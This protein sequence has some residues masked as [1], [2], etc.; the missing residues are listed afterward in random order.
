MFPRSG[1]PSEVL[2]VNTWFQNSER[3]WDQ[4]HHHLQQ[5]VNRHQRFADTY[6]R[7]NPTYQPGQLVWLATQ[8]IRLRQPCR[9]LSPKYIGPFPV[10]RQINPVTYRLHL[11]AQYRI[12]P[13]FHASLLKPHHAPVSVP[14]TDPVPDEDPPLPPI[15]AEPIYT[16]REIQDSRRRGG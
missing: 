9:K 10:E 7:P 2:A 12:H 8:D 13:T 4:A 3:V 16:V 15:D 14:S 1:K 11:P 6:R 5:A